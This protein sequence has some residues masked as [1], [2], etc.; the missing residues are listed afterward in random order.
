[1][2]RT[3]FDETHEVFRLRVRDFLTDEVVPVYAGWQ[4]T[5]RPA[6]A[7]WRRAGEVGILGIGVPAEHGG[8]P[9]SDFRHSVVVTEEAQRLFLALGGV[10]VH[11]DICMP[12]FLHYATAEQQARWLPRL[13]SGDAVVALGLS[14]PGAGSDLAA[15]AT[16]A[17]RE[18]DHYVVDGAK[19][20]ISNGAGA[21]LVVLAVKT[22]PAAGRHGISLLVVATD[23]PG[24][25][26]GARLRKLGLHAQDLAELSFADL[27]V[28]VADRL[29][30]EG[31][32]FAYL[33]SNL[34]QERLS[35][36]VNSQA[37]ATAALTTTAAALAGSGAAQHAKFELAACVAEVAAGQALVDAATAALVAERLSGV[38]A[39][40]AKLYC[41]ELQG[42]VVARCLA[43]LPVGSA[44]AR[45]LGHASLDGRVSRIYGGSSEI[46]KVLIAQP[47]GL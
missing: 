19:T 27:R 24:F 20:F 39:A 44:A 42:R 41:T 35:I 23:S 6:H 37:A 22:D 18:G 32:G 29:G 2:I 5:G 1:M 8:V 16:R 11:T 46:M 28:P 25:Q 17:Q 36:A 43:L 47:L 26:R 9:G 7:F 34:A 4:E 14:E 38:D 13:V 3:L 45:T 21:D 15:M 40:S 30:D 10:R 31:A 33:T 12:Y